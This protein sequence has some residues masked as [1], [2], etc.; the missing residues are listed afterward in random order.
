MAVAVVFDQAVFQGRAAIAQSGLTLEV[1]WPS[2]RATASPASG[3]QLKRTW[4]S[5]CRHS[6]ALKP[7]AGQGQ[8]GPRLVKVRIWTVSVGP[9]TDA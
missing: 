1:G 8:S 9:W 6:P 5:S 7:Q 4:L 2:T 3:A